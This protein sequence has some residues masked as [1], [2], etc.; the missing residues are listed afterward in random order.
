MWLTLPL[1]RRKSWFHIYIRPESLVFLQHSKPVLRF[2]RCVIYNELTFFKKVITYFKRPVFQVCLNSRI[3]VFSTNKTFRIWKR[4]SNLLT[5]GL[6]LIVV[7]IMKKDIPFVIKP[8]VSLILT[9]NRIWRVH[10]DL[11]FSS[12]AN[13]PFGVSES[14]IAWSGTVP[15]IVCNNFNFSML[16]NANTRI[17]CAKINSDCLL[18]ISNNRKSKLGKTKLNSTKKYRLWTRF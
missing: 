18:H 5:Y 11:V 10:G 16:E 13:K 9:K 1:R 2:H 17:C 6:D 12:I 14:D 4:K 15:L 8:Y 7:D 3:T